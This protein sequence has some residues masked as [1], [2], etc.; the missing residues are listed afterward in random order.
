MTLLCD[1]N[2]AKETQNMMQTARMVCL[3]LLCNS[4][5]RQSQIKLMRIP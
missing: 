3:L 4:A 2:E 5:V 1:I